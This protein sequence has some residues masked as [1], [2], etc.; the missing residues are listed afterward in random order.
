MFNVMQSCT[1]LV[2]LSRRTELFVQIHEDQSL[3]LSFFNEG[4]PPII[5]LSSV[6]CNAQI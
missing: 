1:E 6:L 5:F 2:L 4:R 3:T